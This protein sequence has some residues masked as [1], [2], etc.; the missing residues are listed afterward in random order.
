M[1]HKLFKIFKTKPQNG[2]C[3][4]RVIIKLNKPLSYMG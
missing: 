1:D 4:S 2:I 3:H